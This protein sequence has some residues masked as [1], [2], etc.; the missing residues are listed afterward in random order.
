MPAGG[1]PN[2]DCLARGGAAESVEDAALDRGDAVARW[3]SGFARLFEWLFVCRLDWLFAIRH[4]GNR[5]LPHGVGVRGGS[6][7]PTS[8]RPIGVW[9]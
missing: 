5:A 2:G 4:Q 1:E 6:V 9:S 8:P 3:G 7:L